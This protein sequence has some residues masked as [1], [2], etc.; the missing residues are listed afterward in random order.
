MRGIPRI[1]LITGC[2]EAPAVGDT[3][4]VHV[5]FEVFELTTAKG[6]FLRAFTQFDSG[7]LNA[8]RNKTNAY[9]TKVD[10]RGCWTLIASDRTAD[11]FCAAI[12]RAKS[13]RS[14]PR[15]VA[16][17]ATRSAVRYDDYAIERAND[18]KDA[19]DDLR[20]ADLMSLGA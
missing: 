20:D 11:E 1:S 12:A 7:L 4:M 5:D 15:Q 2:D 17:P 18:I 9:F 10:G 3:D 13:R 8:M 6:T 14:A 19:L 16:A